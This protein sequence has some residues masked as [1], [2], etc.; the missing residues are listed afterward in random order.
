MG[1]DAAM[2]SKLKRQRCYF[3]RVS[4]LENH[5]NHPEE[6]SQVEAQ[7]L[8][9]RVRKNGLSKEET[10]RLLELN[11]QAAMLDAHARE[12]IGWT[13]KMVRFVRSCDDADRF[14]VFVD[15]ANNWS[16][17]WNLPEFEPE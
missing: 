15:Y 6:S 2:V 11:R 9:E 1:I 3:D 10:L 14:K 17:V 16:K 13:R 8:Y 5:W 7:E 4:N 12:R